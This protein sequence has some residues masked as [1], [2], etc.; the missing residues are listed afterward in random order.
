MTSP[1]YVYLGSGVLALAAF[2]AI[3][4]LILIGTKDLSPGGNLWKQGAAYR[5]SEE[6]N[7]V[8]MQRFRESWAS[9]W[10]LAA[11]LAVVGAGLIIAGATGA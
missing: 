11:V 4:R 2:W 8:Q 5:E 6:Q 3:M 10:P 1:A 7:D 9:S